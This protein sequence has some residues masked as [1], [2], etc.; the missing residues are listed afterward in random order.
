M[1]FL[2]R[3]VSKKSHFLLC[4]FEYGKINSML[5]LE[6]ILFFV[7]TSKTKSESSETRV[8]LNYCAG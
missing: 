3:K 5:I 8:S 4:D 2:N 6:E 7:E 1:P